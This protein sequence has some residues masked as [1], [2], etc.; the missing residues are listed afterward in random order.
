MQS[1]NTW[2]KDYETSFE[3]QNAMKKKHITYQM[4]PLYNHQANLVERVI[5]T[6]QNHCKAGLS[7]LHPDFLI[8]EWDHLLPQT[9]LTLNLLQPS[10][11][12]PNLSAY[13]YLFG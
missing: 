6:F 12:N 3:L 10:N 7:T 13:T 5:S 1:K 2:I 9:F 8:P 11:F 4:V